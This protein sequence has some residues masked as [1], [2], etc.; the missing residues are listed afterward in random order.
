LNPGLFRLA[1]LEDRDC[2]V[3]L[4][5]PGMGKTTTL[6]AERERRKH[7]IGMS[8]DSL[9][10]RDL[11]EYGQETRLIRD[12]FEGPGWDLWR[13][14]DRALHLYLDAL[15]E[16]RLHL[17]HVT[18]VIV[19]Q[20]ERLPRRDGLKCRI[21][22]RTGAWPHH[23]EAGLRG[24][25]PGDRTGVFE[26]APLRRR[27]V[28]AIAAEEGL[29]DVGAFLKGVERRDA[30]PLA[31]KPVT[32]KLLI[33]VYRRGGQL[34]R[35][36]A[37]LY[38]LGCRALCEEVNEARR[39]AG[40]HGALG[41]DER[42]AVA[43]RIAAATVFCGRSAVRDGPDLA[44][45]P[46]DDIAV[47]DLCG[48]EP[49]RGVE[50]KVTEAGLREVLSDTGLFSARGPGQM[51]WAHRTFAEFLAARYLAARGLGVEQVKGLVLHPH[52]PGRVVPQ[53]QQATPWLAGMIPEVFRAILASDP[54]V[55]VRSDVENAATDDREALVAAHFKAA[56]EGRLGDVGPDARFERR[57]LKHPRLAAQ[58]SPVITDRSAGLG[59]RRMAIEVAR[60]CEVRE[61]QGPLA[62]LMLDRTEDLTI[63]VEAGYAVWKFGD[64]PT[65]RRVEPLL[66]TDLKEDVEDELSGCALRSLWPGLIPAGEVF[67][68]ITPPKRGNLYSAYAGF[69]T[70]DLARGLDRADLPLALEWA[71]RQ[72]EP[73]SLAHI[74]R[75]VIDQIILLACD[76]LDVPEIADALAGIVWARIESLTEVIDLLSG[77]VGKAPFAADAGRRRE[78]VRAL[79]PKLKATN[80]QPALLCFSRPPLVIAED[81]PWLIGLLDLEEDVASRTILA[82]LV[83]AVFLLPSPRSPDEVLAA[84]ERRPELAE[85]MKDLILPVALDSPVAVAGRKMYADLKAYE[86]RSRANRTLG[87]PPREWVEQLLAREQAGDP[88]AWWE[89]TRVMTLESQS[90]LYKDT[91]RTDLTALPGWREA[92]AATRGRIVEAAHRYVLSH[93]PSPDRWFFQAGKVY[94]PD[95]AGL[96]ALRLLSEQA[97]DRFDA[98][99]PDVWGKWS[100]VIV[101]YPNSGDRDDEEAQRRLTGHAYRNA[102][103]ELLDWLTRW[104]E[105]QGCR[106]NPHLSVRLWADLPGSA[107]IGILM[108]RARDPSTNPWVMETLLDDLVT[109]DI[110]GA[111]EFAT[112]LLGLPCLA[113]AQQRPRSL[114]AA[115]SLLTCAP[116]AGWPTVWPVLQSDPDFGRDLVDSIAARTDRASPAP[117]L[118]RLSEDQ[119]ADLYIWIVRH[120]ARQE[121]EEND[122]SPEDGV[123]ECI[124]F[125]RHGVLRHLERL[126]T[127]GSLIALDRIVRELP[128]LTWLSLVRLEAEKVVM[129]RTWV[130]HRPEDLWA[131]AGDREARL[132]DGGDQ[133]LDVVI[134]SLGRYQR[135]LR[136]ETPASFMLWDRQANKKF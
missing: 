104:L 91:L 117:F 48:V 92:D 131:L 58:L 32:L 127:A 70:D 102:P 87:L 80:G 39:A 9:I 49:V 15:D 61:L 110:P 31:A 86:L 134:E 89:L 135:K 124:A 7:E 25:W 106:E 54:E 16:C 88:D 116:D 66:A 94:L 118:F 112:S 129:E 21:A 121:D 71:A 45:W 81:L 5:E 136:G 95:E 113:E 34:P 12:L 84:A 51:G 38:E 13:A 109:R 33:N 79:V 73:E 108:D 67:R 75:L 77:R 30:G 68:A 119:V 43:A 8:G 40:Q 19:R 72:G 27:D 28:E 133:L 69:L 101:G 82:R 59:A 14:G 26:L 93:Q 125:F 36:Q 47:P 44:Q 63:R 107:P 29:T 115:R 22:C 132:V 46:E 111:R 53:L 100:P 17:P 64:E 41:V 126:G 128:H 4:G 6:E 90:N 10:W 74:V 20:L 35:S 98:L 85:A 50:F 78:L 24:L 3:L 55:L 37:E 60:A 103:G 99:D 130:P 18:A 65:R 42:L 97:P 52:M 122:D 120:F 2:L 105:Q 57:K 96:K 11:G 83:R 114:A 1:Q 56:A 76:E 23:L 62:D 123:R